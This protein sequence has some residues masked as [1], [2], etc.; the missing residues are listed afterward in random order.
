VLGI[1]RDVLAIGRERDVAKDALRARGGDGGCQ[2]CLASRERL[3]PSGQTQDGL[4]S[5][6][7]GCNGCQAR[8]TPTS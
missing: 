2:L 8:P 4:R 3:L 5:R 7:W 6:G 1:K